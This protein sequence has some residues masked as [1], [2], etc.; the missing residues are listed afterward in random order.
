MQSTVMHS[1]GWLSTIL[2]SLTIATSSAVA[3]YYRYPSPYQPGARYAPYGWYHRPA[4][5]GGQWSTFDGGLYGSYGGYQPFAIRPYG[6]TNYANP[7]YLWPAFSSGPPFSLD[8][9]TYSLG[10]L[11]NLPSARA[12]ALEIQRGEIEIQ[13]QTDTT[14]PV[15]YSLGGKIFAIKPGESQKRTI[16]RPT[17]IAF[18]SGGTKGDLRYTLKPGTYRFI[19]TDKGWDLKQVVPKATSTGKAASSSSSTDQNH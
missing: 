8:N 10:A 19:A 3:Q 11:R 2:L 18:G 14:I 16:E 6:G 12:L 5:A 9:G 4:Y 1:T 17:V 13:H 7:P 15:N